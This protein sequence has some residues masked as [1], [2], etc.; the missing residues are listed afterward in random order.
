MARLYCKIRKG[1]L[2][3]NRSSFDISLCCSLLANMRLMKTPIIARYWTRITDIFKTEES[4]AVLRSSGITSQEK[5]QINVQNHD[6]KTIE[7][8]HVASNNILHHIETRQT[9]PFYVNVQH[10]YTS[11]TTK[12]TSSRTEEDIKLRKSNGKFFPA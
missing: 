10:F 4:S 7:C 12:L 1:N 11:L 3:R 9:T 8:L 5:Y 2:C 6:L